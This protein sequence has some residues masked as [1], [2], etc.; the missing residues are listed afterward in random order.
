MNP[1]RPSP[2]EQL[3]PEAAARVDAACDGF[4]MA[5]KATRCGAAAP[6][7]SNFLDAC[8]GSERTVLAGELLAL[9]RACRE[10]YGLADRPEGAQE[11]GAGAEAPSNCAT[12][13]QRPRADVPAGRAAEWPS[14]PGLVFVEV[15]GSGGMGVV[16]KARQARLGRNVAVKFLRDAHR[17]DPEQHQRFLQEALAVAR[18]RHPNLVQLYEFGEVPGAGGI[19]SRPYLVLEYVHGGSLAELTH[20]S[21][22]P[23]R[24]AARLVEAMADA[25]HYA[26][27]QGSSTAT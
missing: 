24:E 21:P 14:I 6:R 12:R 4:E 5:W 25:I 11:L 2:Y 1:E 19:T 20:G 26:H 13:P 16:F 23:P 17:A 22:Q 8:E 15:L 10:R 3:S 27:Q 9:D 18:L 7:L